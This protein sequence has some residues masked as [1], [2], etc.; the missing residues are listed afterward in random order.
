MFCINGR[1]SW[2]IIF[3]ILFSTI[4]ILVAD[5]LWRFVQISYLA[6]MAFGI[7]LLL[8]GNARDIHR[9]LKSAKI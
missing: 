8:V 7:V 4:V 5:I 2:L 1:I 6:I 3:G 9:Q